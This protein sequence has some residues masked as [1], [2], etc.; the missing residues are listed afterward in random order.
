MTPTIDTRGPWAMPD[1]PTHKRGCCYRVNITPQYSGD[2]YVEVNLQ[3]ADGEIGDVRVMF[4]DSHFRVAAFLPGRSECP[5]GDTPKMVPDRD[6]WTE[7]RREANK[8]FA[9]YV[10]AAFRDGWTPMTVTGR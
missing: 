5:P 7:D 1:H 2:S 9:Q 3:K 8:V 6:H 10:I 4:Y